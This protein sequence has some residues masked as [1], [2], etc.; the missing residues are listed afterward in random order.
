MSEES[1]T[2]ARGRFRYKQFALGEQWSS[3]HE[4][5]SI[6]QFAFE[7]RVISPFGVKVFPTPDIVKF[8][9]EPY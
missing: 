3:W 9:V 5:Q 4:F 8:E 7:I 2:W 6:S 1:P